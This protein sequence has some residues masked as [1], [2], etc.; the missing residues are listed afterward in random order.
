MRA[1]LPFVLGLAALLAAAPVAAQ[2][3][4]AERRAAAADGAIRIHNLAGSVRVIGWDRDSIVVRGTIGAGSE[5]FTMHVS[6]RNAKLGI[7]PAS[8][9]APPAALEVHVPRRSQ[10]WIKTESAPV[11]IDEV[12]GGLDISSVSGR[13]EVRGAPR[14]LFAESMGGTIDLTV[15]TRVLRARTAGA[16]IVVRG[17]VADAEVL[18]VSG[19]VTV[20]NKQ[21]TRGRFESVDGAVRY[22]GGIARGSIVEFITHSGAIDI[23]LLRGSDAE[24][25]VS[26]FQ[27]EVESLLQGKLIQRGGRGNRQY[28]LTL[29]RGG[30]DI[31]VRT[32]KGQVRLGYR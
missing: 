1:V 5:P 20:E 30:A 27:G 19:N 6:G 11:L 31:R 23:A 15:D 29:G 17:R 22:G 32:F 14:E 18:S 10:V 21:V 13:I 8:G 2:R 3:P 28:S 4:I 26:S 12:S 9:E 24:L 7:W 25:T 16:D